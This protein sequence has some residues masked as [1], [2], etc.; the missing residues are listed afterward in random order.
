MGCTYPGTHHDQPSPS[1][2]NIHEQGPAVPVNNSAASAACPAW[3]GG[4]PNLKSSGVL[5]VDGTLYWAI[6]W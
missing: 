6:S 3:H 2:K 5:S 1:C 4:V